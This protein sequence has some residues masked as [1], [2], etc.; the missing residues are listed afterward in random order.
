MTFLKRIFRPTSQY[1]R[2]LRRYVD[3]EYKDA[4]DRERV[5]TKLLE[6]R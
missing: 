3:I 6:D 2:D 1:K 4:A 5:Y